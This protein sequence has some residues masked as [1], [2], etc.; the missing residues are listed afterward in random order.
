MKYL[1]L[2]LLCTSSLYAEEVP[3]YLK[4]GK[5]V[6][7]LTNGKSYEFSSNEYMVVRRGSKVDAELEPAALQQKHFEQELHHKN[8]LRLL[9]GAGPSGL[10]TS[11]SGS[12]VNVKSK[13]ELVT[14]LGYDRSLTNELSIG[15]S[16]YTN[17]T[18][19][20]GFGTDF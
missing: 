13:Y 20:L 14:G 8:R 1:F 6:V 18:F 12:T 19:S 10:Q 16:V 17:G 9:I 7:T 15:G 2:I 3:A 5:I 4:D 11:Q